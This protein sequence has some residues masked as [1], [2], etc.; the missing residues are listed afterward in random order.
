MISGTLNLSR[1]LGLV[2]G[3]AVMGAVFAWA[4]ASSDVTTAPPEAVSTGLRVTFTVAALLVA[5]GACHGKRQRQGPA[6]HSVPKRH[7]SGG[8][9]SASPG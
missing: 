6:G 1:N 4:S 5:G 3:A 8:R 2:S 9:H 7:G